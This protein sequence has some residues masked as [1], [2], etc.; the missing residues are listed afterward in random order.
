MTMLYRGNCQRELQTSL[1]MKITTKNMYYILLEAWSLCAWR[2]YVLRVRDHN[3]RTNK[4][5]GQN[6]T[7]IFS[8]ERS[9]NEAIQSEVEQLPPHEGFV[10]NL[11]D[12]S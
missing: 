3:D 2:L 5:S 11:V 12:A 9:G 4:L 7:A 10:H 6:K 8:I 1:Q